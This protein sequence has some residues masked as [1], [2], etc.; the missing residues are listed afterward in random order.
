ML[1]NRMRRFFQDSEGFS[2]IE[3]VI[4]LVIISITLIPL[5]R[6]AVSNTK[7]GAIYVMHTRAMIFAQGVMEHI[8]ADYNSDS[9]TY[10]GYDNV[11]ANWSSAASGTSDGMDWNVTISPEYE[12]NGI[13]YR[14][15]EVF[16]VNAGRDS[17][18]ISLKT[19][20]VK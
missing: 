15:V 18:G 8:I 10:G 1:K 6:L 2:L 5:S 9:A 13:Y 17:E 19:L 16:V 12:S 7:A 20:I 11:V 3:I 4:I 14:E